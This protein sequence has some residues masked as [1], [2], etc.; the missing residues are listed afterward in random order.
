MEGSGGSVQIFGIYWINE[1]IFQGGNWWIESMKAVDRE[2]DDLSW[3]QAH[4]GEWAHRSSRA[5]P[6]HGGSPGQLQHK[7]GQAGNLIAGT[8]RQRSSRER[9]LTRK[10]AGG[11]SSSTG[12]PYERGEKVL[13]V[14]LDAVEGGRGPGRLL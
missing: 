10:I 11:E 1:I 5:A 6:A 14:G 2:Q 3:T 12:Q 9:L 8:R 4:T 13:R 7:E